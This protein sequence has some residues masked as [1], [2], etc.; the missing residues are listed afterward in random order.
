MVML[1]G[2]RDWIRLK[3]PYSTASLDMARARLHFIVFLA[4]LGVP[5]SSGNY[6]PKSLIVNDLPYTAEVS[7]CVSYCLGL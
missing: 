7:L 1:R 6:K 3:F 2:Y 4:P 5:S